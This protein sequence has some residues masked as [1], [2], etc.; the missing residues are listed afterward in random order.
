MPPFRARDRVR[1]LKK[2]TF[3]FV[4]FVVHTDFSSVDIWQ[5][6]KNRSLFLQLILVPSCL[7]WC[8]ERSKVESLPSGKASCE[9]WI[10]VTA[11]GCQELKGSHEESRWAVPEHCPKR[12]LWLCSE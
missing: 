1:G 6:S 12:K 10:S 9:R 2:L 11:Q 5:H 3:R 7:S 4:D 8:P